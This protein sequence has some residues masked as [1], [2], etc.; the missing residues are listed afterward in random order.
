MRVRGLI[1]EAGKAD[2]PAESNTRKIADLYA[3][4]MNEDAIEAKGSHRSSLTWMP[5]QQSRTERNWRTRWE[6][7]CGR[8]SMR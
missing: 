2:A 7:R 8:T 1:E 3:S 6:R 4:Y 5:S